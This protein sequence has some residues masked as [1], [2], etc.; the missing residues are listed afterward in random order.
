MKPG[1]AKTKGRETE[2]KLVDYLMLNGFIHAERRRLYGIT[3]R[4]DIAGV[5]G[6]CIEVKS[7]ASLDLSGWLRELAAEVRNDGAD[8]GVVVVRPKGKPNVEDWYAIMPV[9]QLVDLMNSTV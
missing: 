4:G 2:N 7:G 3:D 1:T 9:P 8:Y 6:W 5:I